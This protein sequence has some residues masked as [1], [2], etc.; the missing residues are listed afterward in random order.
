MRTIASTVTHNLPIRLC[1]LHFED[2]HLPFVI[3]S[4]TPTLGNLTDD[5]VNSQS[6]H[7]ELCSKNLYVTYDVRDIRDP[8]MRR[9]TAKSRNF[10]DHVEENR[11]R[12]DTL[13][14]C[15][16]SVMH[17]FR[18]AVLNNPDRTDMLSNKR[19]EKVK[20]LPSVRFSPPHQSHLCQPQKPRSKRCVVGEE[21]WQQK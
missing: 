2:R 21:A 4:T 14:F 7:Q 19:P 20:T 10:K 18:C 15:F 11:S 17:L 6:D 5:F 9:H 13:F 8:V 12:R 16:H 1:G 3:R